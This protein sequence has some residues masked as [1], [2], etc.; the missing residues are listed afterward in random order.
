M[1]AAAAAAAVGRRAFS[2]GIGAILPSP[3]GAGP[4]SWGRGA[5]AAGDALPANPEDL[6][7]HAESVLQR[8]HP[9][10]GAVVPVDRDLAE[11]H[12]SPARDEQQLDVEGPAVV[13]LR[14]E[15][16]LRR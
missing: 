12:A 9:A 10:V 4:G 13:G 16:L 2:G 5:V 7:R 8:A 6:E 14:P 3:A 11:H 1:T 15:E